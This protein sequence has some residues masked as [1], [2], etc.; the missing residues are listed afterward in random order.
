VRPNPVDLS[1]GSGLG[2]IILWSATFAFAR[3]LS[4]KVGPL[5]GGAA[6]YLIGGSFCL[7]RLASSSAPWHRL[8]QLPPLYLFGCGSLFVFY[9][10]V[11]YLAVG[12]AKKREQLLGIAL[13][14]CIRSTRFYRES[15]GPGFCLK[16][17]N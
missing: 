14:I 7:L 11:L 9:T 5:T 15:A 4:E 3:N 10:A 17:I 8:L 16:M 13:A 1:T 6:V 12:L 2:A